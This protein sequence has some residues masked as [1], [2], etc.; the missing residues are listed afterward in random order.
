NI[1]FTIHLGDV[2]D[3][4]GKPDQWKVADAAMKILEDAKLPYSVLAGNHDV[5]NDVDFSVDPVGGTDANRTPANEPYIQWFGT[6]RAKKQAT[7][8]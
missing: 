8:G 4:V 6:E 1:P 2:V 5:L 7:F 3:Q